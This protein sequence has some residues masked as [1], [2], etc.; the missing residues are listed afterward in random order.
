[1]A[2]R[3]APAPA[4]LA[5]HLAAYAESRK[6]DLTTEAV[7]FGDRHS[8]GFVDFL[9]V[10]EKTTK[11]RARE[12]GTEPTF[13]ANPPYHLLKVKNGRVRVVR[14]ADDGS[15]VDRALNILGVCD[16][17]TADHVLISETGRFYSPSR[18]DGAEP[19]HG[20]KDGM[21]FVQVPPRRARDGQW[22]V[23]PQA[24]RHLVQQAEAER[25]VAEAAE[26]AKN[27]AEQALA[28][29]RHGAALDLIR[30]VL[31]AAGLN[32]TDHISVWANDTS[33]VVTLRLKNEEIEYVG[34][35]LDNYKITAASLQA[36]DE[37]EL[38]ESAS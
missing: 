19:I 8:L 11:T 9:M 35:T 20:E 17:A 14:L 13:N 37:P 26:N 7:P 10:R 1:M 5:E 12:W 16:A 33:T 3:T 18:D 6:A 27:A 34:D 21:K 15:N 25:A 23:T 2:P 31:V 28:E 24:L 30:G 4:K 32:P 29:S 38:T 22:V 36:A